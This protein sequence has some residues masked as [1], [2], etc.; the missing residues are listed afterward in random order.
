M[1]FLAVPLACL[2]FL[3]GCNFCC[4]KDSCCP[5][6]KQTEEVK[7]NETEDQVITQEIENQEVSQEVEEASNDTENL[8]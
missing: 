1:K 5:T 8:K 7:Q 4:K 2:V 3:S 6:E